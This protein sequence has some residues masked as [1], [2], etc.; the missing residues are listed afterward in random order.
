MDLGFAGPEAYTIWEVLGKTLENYIYKIRYYSIKNFRKKNYYC[1]LNTPPK[2]FYPIF[3][4]ACFL[5]VTDLRGENFHLDQLS[6]LNVPGVV[7][8]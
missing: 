4:G 3:L 2:P 6:I 1:S 7:Q 5:V 8:V